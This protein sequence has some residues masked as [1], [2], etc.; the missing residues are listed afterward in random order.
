M[1]NARNSCQ[2]RGHK[3]D[4]EPTWALNVMLPDQSEDDASFLARID[5]ASSYTDELDARD[6]SRKH[7]TYG[8]I[9]EHMMK[10]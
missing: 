3:I 4:S 8:K 9:Y 2:N 10:I 7:G 5:A 1:K 6:A